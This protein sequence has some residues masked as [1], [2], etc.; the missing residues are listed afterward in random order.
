MFTVTPAIEVTCVDKELMSTVER[1]D[2]DVIVPV[3]ETFVEE[4]LME[5]VPV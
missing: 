4:G 1:D 2:S 3:D 5:D